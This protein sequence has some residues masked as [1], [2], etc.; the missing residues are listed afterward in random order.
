MWDANQCEERGT[1]TLE[2]QEASDKIQAECDRLF[3]LVKCKDIGVYMVEPFDWFD[4]ESPEDYGLGTKSSDDDIRKEA[5]EFLL[6]LNENNT[7]IYGDL[8]DL[9]K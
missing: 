7:M 5:A 6:Y 8:F 2:A 3:E 9:L 4:G 1:L